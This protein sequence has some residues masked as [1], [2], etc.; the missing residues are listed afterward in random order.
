MEVTNVF[1][2]SLRNIGLSDIQI[3]TLPATSDEFGPVCSCNGLEMFPYTYPDGTLLYR[4]TDC[5]HQ[6]RVGGEEEK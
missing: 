2:G 3:S 6:Y 5:G 1:Y 4:C